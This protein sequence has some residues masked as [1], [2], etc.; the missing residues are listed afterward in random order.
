MTT[1]KVIGTRGV[2]MEKHSKDKKPT[3]HEKKTSLDSIKELMKKSP[4]RAK[5]ELMRH[6][7]K[8]P[9]DMYGWHFYGKLAADI[10]D[11]EEAEYAFTKVAESKSWN[12]YAGVVGL[13]DVA[14]K[15]GE[16]ELAKKYYRQAI[17]EN[18]NEKS[19]TFCALA[20][21]ECLDE[22]YEEAIKVLEMANIQDNEIMIS[23]MQTYVL[24]GDKEAALAIA[25]SIIPTKD[26]ERM[27]IAFEKAKLALL[28]DKKEEAKQLLALAKSYQVK[29]KGYY[30]I[31]NTEALLA[32]EENNLDLAERN[33]Q[34]CLADK[35]T[36]NGDIYITLGR[37][38]QLKGE[39]K[40]SIENFELATK[41]IN[42]SRITKQAGLLYGALIEMA[43]GNEEKATQMFE[44]SLTITKE[45]Y[46]PIIEN[47][48]GIYCKNGQY[49]KMREV[50]SKCRPIAKHVSLVS[51]LNFVEIVLKVKLGE[52]LPPITKCNYRER[53]VI[54]YN[55]EAAIEHIKTQHLE[56]S[57]PK[58]TPNDFPE[59]EDISRGTFASSI[60]IEELYD[61]VLPQLT[62]ETKVRTG[63]VDRYVI[64]Y[65]NAGYTGNGEIVNF[66][67]VV[68][69]PNTYDI[70]SMFPATEAF[71]IRKC[72]VRDYLEKEEQ[73]K[74]TN[75]RVAKFNN[76]FANYT[77]K[78]G[79]K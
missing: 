56:G 6:L 16:R 14:R 3:I 57:T 37:V 43:L 75:S 31:L 47:L 11:F 51:S 76:R 48:C 78:N 42:V 23:K 52:E 63:L 65:P 17:N 8:Y 60:N 59:A 13:G 7:E 15:R 28:E 79:N 38:K 70:I 50:V 30:G 21:M 1:R 36:V 72:D 44:E 73:K 34:E 35:V 53:Q 24:K 54:N 2:K 69:L 27:T 58:N 77:S 19:H 32:L 33:C 66:V 74:K 71:T 22:N 55:K 29:G 64:D 4:S 41:Q 61:E 45:P 18:P 62:E 49:D 40:E 5:A 68:T 67:R 25:E 39:Y 9:E 12:K 10:S 46:T 26:E 20:R